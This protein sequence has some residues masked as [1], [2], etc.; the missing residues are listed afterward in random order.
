MENQIQPAYKKPQHTIFVSRSQI[1]ASLLHRHPKMYDSRC[2]TQFVSD[3]YFSVF[4]LAMLVSCDVW[5]SL[6]TKTHP[7]DQKNETNLIIYGSLVGASFIF[8]IIRAFSFYLVSLRCS[9]RLHDKMAA[10]VLQAPVVFFD[11]NPVGRIMNRFSKDI[12]CMDDVLPK[13]FLR[14]IQRTLLMFTSI[15]LP[16]VI[17]PWLLFALTPIA[18]LAGVISRYYL[19]TSRELQR[20]ESVSRSPVF[21]HFSETLDGLDT[22]RTRKREKDFVDEFC[23]YFTHC[24]C[25]CF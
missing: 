22:I 12:S 14:A 1:N 4:P 18:V 11:S 20:L 9:E 19:K 10:A 17:N 7:E 21:S 3:H 8:L 5:L 15:L 24:F 16:T 23:R 13:T 6:L 25:L 2:M